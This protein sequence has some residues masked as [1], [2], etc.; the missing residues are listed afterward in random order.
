M[1]FLNIVL[2]ALRACLEWYCLI[3]NLSE[4]FHASAAANM[5]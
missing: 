4:I 5:F 3:D 1:I 2:I